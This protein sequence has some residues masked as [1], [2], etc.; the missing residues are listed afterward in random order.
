MM[1]KYA[2]AALISTAR[3]QFLQHPTVQARANQVLLKNTNNID[4]VGTIF[5]GSEFSPVN[6]L[7]DTTTPWTSILT[8][9]LG[10]YSS[11]DVDQS[12]SAKPVYVDD[13]STVIMSQ[14]LDLGSI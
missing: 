12:G 1:N 5:V 3:A 2:V 9:G 7:F 14:N 11:Y 13:E 6:V 4:Y 8:E 10:E